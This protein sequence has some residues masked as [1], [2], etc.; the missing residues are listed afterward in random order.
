[1]GRGRRIPSKAL[2]VWVPARTAHRAPRTAPCKP[3]TEHRAPRIGLVAR[4]IRSPLRILFAGG[5]T[6]GHLYPGLAIARALK[7]LRPDVEVMFVG[8]TRGVERDVLP[9]TGFPYLLLDLHPLYR[10]RPWLN[11]RTLRGFASAWRALGR[12]VREV[13]PALVVGTGGYA[14]G[15]TL[16]Y[17]I[18]HDIPVA[19]QEQNSYP[20]LTTRLASR[21]AREIYLGYGEAASFLRPR[22]GAWVGETGNPIEPPPETTPDRRSARREWGFPESGGNVLLVFGGSQGS[23]AINAAMRDWIRRGL[24]EH[25]YV[26]WGTGRTG[27]DDVQSLE[28]PKVRIAQYLSPITDAYAASDLALTRAGALTSAELNAWG[29]PSVLIP[30]PTAA[31]DHQTANAR[32]LVAVGAAVMLPQNELSAG[33]LETEVGGLLNSPEKLAALAARAREQGKP[34]AAGVIAKRILGLVTHVIV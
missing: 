9:T 25:V 23:R 27:Y 28:S 7:A 21:F 16:A 10:T 14:S 19:I 12:L 26:I 5:G 2:S 32:A 17:A 1:M 8:A 29:I 20:G 6:G 31:A 22:Q 3:G 24:P 30:L 11:F 4:C 33:R 18:T 34:N 15:A 13:R